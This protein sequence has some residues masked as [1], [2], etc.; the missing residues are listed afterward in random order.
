MTLSIF[1]SVLTN[2][3]ILFFLM[4]EYK[5]Y[6]LSKFMYNPNIFIHHKHLNALAKLAISTLPNESC[7]ILLGKRSSIKPVV[8]YILPM[9]NSSNSSTEFNIEA[10]DLYYAYNKARLMN[11]DI[12]AIFHSHPS[13]PIPSDM[14]K[15]FM[16]INPIVWIIYST[17]SHTF[18]AFILDQTDQLQEISIHLIRD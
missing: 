14:D 8:H 16:L 10:D 3:I 11:L 13:Q 1:I 12:I 6:F 9:N 18:K 5:G 4:Y 17:L 15:T 2:N 7:A